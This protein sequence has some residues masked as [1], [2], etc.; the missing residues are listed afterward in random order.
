MVYFCFT[1]VTWNHKKKTKS[2][3]YSGQ[4]KHFYFFWC[5][6]KSGQNFSPLDFNL[7]GPALQVQ[8][9]MRSKLKYESAAEA[10]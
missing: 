3:S 7:D 2:N 6:Q 5:Y 9:A 10:P 1:H 8:A 4:L